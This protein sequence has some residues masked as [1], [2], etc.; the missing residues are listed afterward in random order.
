M[1]LFIS[2]VARLSI[3]AATVF[4]MSML[5]YIKLGLICQDGLTLN[6]AFRLCLCY[7]KELS[8]ATPP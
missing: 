1:C 8:S 3:A 6:L 4:G 2:S 7:N 5:N